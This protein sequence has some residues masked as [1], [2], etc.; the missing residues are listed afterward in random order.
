MDLVP[1]IAGRTVTADAL[2]K[3]TPI[4]DCLHDRGAHFMFV[5]K[6]NQ[7]NLL[8]EIR[9]HFASQCPRPADFATRSPQ[10]EHGQIEQREICVSTDPVHRLSLPW[11]GQVFMIKRTVREYR[12]V[13]NGKPARLDKPSV[14]IVCG[15]TS[16]TPESADAEALLGFNRA[17]WLCERIVEGAVS[18]VREQA[19]HGDQV[20]VLAIVPC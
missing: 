6:R 13:R 2:L 18:A 14:E 10:P 4:S 8:K 19:R 7:R 5:A 1:D 16:H 17:H 12:C 20:E 3:Q 11:V 15:I 9:G